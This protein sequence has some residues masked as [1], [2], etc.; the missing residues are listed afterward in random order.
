[1]IKNVAQKIIS[2]GGKIIPLIVPYELGTNGT[3]LCNP[4]I[5][6]EGNEIWIN[7]R[8]IQ[9]SLYHTLG[10]YKS[11]YGPL[12]YLN[13]DNDMT[14]TTKN[15]LGKL[16]DDN[17]EQ[18]KLVDMKLDQPPIWEFVGLEDA[19][20][21]K[22][23]SKF[24]LSGVRRDTTP[25]GEGRMELSEIQNWEEIS[26][27]RIPTTND[28]S[29]Y[30]EKNWMPIL[31]KPYHFIKWL[32][33][34]E[35]VEYDGN[36]THIQKLNNFTIPTI[37]DLRGGSQVVRIGDNYYCV[38]HETNLWYTRLNQKDATYRHRLIKF[39]LN[40]NIVEV[41]DEFMFLDGL[42]EF[43]C[44]LAYKDNWVYITFGIED[45]AAYCAKISIIQFFKLFYE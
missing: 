15:Y 5:F 8:H 31:D 6:I 12:A 1:M 11:R 27:E 14:L 24:Y 2:S 40:F 19:R 36:K 28:N 39:D 13:P 23:N 43:C 44:G 32:N 42:I 30:C 45:N 35:I 4:S 3:G 20:I 16:V 29:A 21:V 26:R 22:W 37:K 10:K 38:A 18:I 7:V 34:V 41:S 25:N 33:P 17:F 9:Y